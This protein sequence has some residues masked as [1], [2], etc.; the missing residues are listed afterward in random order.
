VLLLVGLVAAAFSPVR[1]AGYLAL[2]D[3]DYVTENDT[4]RAGLHPR[5]LA[6]A[7]TTFS[8]ANWHPLTWV[9]HMLDVTLFG[10][11]PEPAHRVNVAL[12]A[13]T[14][15]LL[16][17][18]LARLTG[19]RGASLATAALFAV[20]PLRVESVAWIAERKDLLAGLLGVLT[21]LAYA[22]HVRRPGPGRLG[23]VAALFV[24]GLMAK[25]MLVTL[26]LL[27]LLLDWWP[28]GRLRAARPGEAAP[29]APGPGRLLLE[30]AP[31]L[32]LSAGSSVI[33]FAAQR[34]GGAM[35]SADVFPPGVRL[36]NACVA[37]AAYL[38]KALWPH[39]LIPFYPHPGLV[40]TPREVAG[41]LA[42]LAG[43]TAVAVAARRRRPWLLVGWLWFLGML[44]PVI[45]LVQV[46][47]QGMADRYSYLP[48]VGPCAALAWET[49]ARLGRA[50]RG[51]GRAGAAAAGA[52]AVLAV[53]TW[54][55]A[56]YWQATV[57]LYDRV[58]AVD[59]RNYLAYNVLGKEY[60][61]RGETAR[62][63]G[64]LEASLALRPG[65]L[66][67]RYNL[68]LALAATGEPDAAVREFS[69]VIL[70]DPDDAESRFNRG[71]L[72]LRSGRPAAA[73][74]DF[75][76]AAARAPGRAQ[77]HFSRGL[78][79][80]RLGRHAEAA[81]AFEAAAALEPRS[82]ETQYNLGRALDEAG[83]TAEAEERYRRALALDP[84][85]AAAH[86]MLGVLLARQGRLEEGASHFREAVRLDPADAA[87]R[88]N[89]DRAAGTPG[90]GR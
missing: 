46:G 12:H 51:R 35:A 56:G 10:P 20:H 39:G 72:L 27:M 61:R 73:L 15:A 32:L 17:L 55:Q 21:L 7:L 23:A 49:R 76:A 36:A 78:A 5:G 44:V 18:L 33:T 63:R 71:K 31:L 22:R 29:G 43:L 75:D 83:R 66:P 48:L 90:R 70:A 59:P 34:A 2:D 62:A 38:G 11:G 4:V 60:L 57:P 69:A 88:A 41:S 14:A 52:V 42:L 80:A 28:L 19:A 87:A 3:P 58:I 47:L 79:L 74:P 1:N 54:R 84:G 81:A 89:L 8:A 85:L 45:G 68:G 50:G 30:K 82:A 6:W 65:F 13:A 67:A 26:P 77:V 64:L 16:L 40:L 37:Y 86:N 25:P 24:L 9:S 53:M